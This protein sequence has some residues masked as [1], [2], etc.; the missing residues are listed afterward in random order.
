MRTLT[1]FVAGIIAGL[2]IAPDKG[3]NTRREV[4]KFIDALKGG[5]NNSSKEHLVT[6]EE[7]INS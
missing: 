2:L 3:S 4:S 1:V 7:V 6:S 5:N